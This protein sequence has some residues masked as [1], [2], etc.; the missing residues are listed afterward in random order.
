MITNIALQWALSALFILTTAYAVVWM[1]RSWTA[2]DRISYLAHALMGLAMFAMIWPWG[3][4]TWIVPQIVV[5]SFATLWF[6]FLIGGHGRHPQAPG[7]HDGH[8]NSSGQLAYHAGMMASMV[9]MGFAM[10]AYGTASVSTGDLAGIDDM[11]GMDAA[12]GMASG[13]SSPVWVT[14]ISVTCAL[15]FAVATVYFLRSTVVAATAPAAPTE[16]TRLG[17]YRTADAVWNL[18]MAAGMLVLFLPLIS[19]G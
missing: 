2:G 18:L 14:V 13:M 1:V 5:F 17:G 8:H 12:G 11:S 4:Q 16:R 7:A 19:F 3:M 6:L 15:G 9:G 10:L